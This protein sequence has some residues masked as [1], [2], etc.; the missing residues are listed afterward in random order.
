MY[1]DF[2]E[3]PIWR[4]GNELLMELYT[5]SERF[6]SE[7]KFSLIS[8]I[9]RSGNSVIANIAESHGRFSYKDK[10]RVLYIA[11]GEIAE[12]RSHLAVAFGRKYIKLE[13]FFKLNTRYCK[14]AKEMNLYINSL[15]NKK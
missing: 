2:Y 13:K 6:P 3:L 11:R 8:Q 1:K 12:T 7:E 15:V 4:D 10:I 14:L 9:R 5:I